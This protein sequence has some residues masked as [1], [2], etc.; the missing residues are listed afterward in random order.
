MQDYP[1]AINTLNHNGPEIYPTEFGGIYLPRF[2]RSLILS[3]LGEKWGTHI[4]VTEDDLPRCIDLCIESLGNPVDIFV[5]EYNP[6][7]ISFEKLDCEYTRG[8]SNFY[9]FVEE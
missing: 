9:H 7:D 1:N 4:I 8:V 2:P 6:M 3:Y 5:G